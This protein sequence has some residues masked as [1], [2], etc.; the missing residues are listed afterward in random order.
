LDKGGKDGIKDIGW[1]HDDNYPIW[2][3]SK[4]YL[5]Q[6]DLMKAGKKTFHTGKHDHRMFDEIGSVTYIMK[7][8]YTWAWVMNIK[9]KP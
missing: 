8:M 5:M 1:D 2:P 9:I 3:P 7:I 4:L 6:S